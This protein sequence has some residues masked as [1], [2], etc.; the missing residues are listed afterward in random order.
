MADF[1][2]SETQGSIIIISLSLL[3]LLKILV[4]TSSYSSPTLTTYTSICDNYIVQNLWKANVGIALLATI[5]IT[6]KHP[7]KL[8]ELHQTNILAIVLASSF[9]IT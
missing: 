6:T 2:M 1:V 3:L 5:T 4:T 7:Q 8:C 9:I